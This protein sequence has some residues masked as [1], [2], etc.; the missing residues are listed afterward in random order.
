[1]AFTCKSRRVGLEAGYSASRCAVGRARWVWARS[2]RS[3]W[4]RRAKKALE[5]RKQL[6]DGLDPIG[7]RDAALAKHRLDAAKA[8]T[9]SECQA[10]YIDAHRSS[11]HNVKHAAQWESTLKT[12]AAPTLGALPVQTVDVDLVTRVLEPIWHSKPETAA[13]LRGR[14]EAI[15]DWATVR[16]Q[17]IGDN[18]ARWRGNLQK[19]LPARSKVKPVEHHPALAFPELPVFMA[20]L[21]GQEGV[22]ARALEFTILTAARTGEVIGAVPSEIDF[23]AK[24][25][26]IPTARMKAKR[27]HRVPLSLASLS[28]I[29]AMRQLGNDHFLFPGGRAVLRSCT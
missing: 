1:V 27:E 17:R 23:V 19:L 16:G 2:R 21:R 24:A 20:S 9:F 11:W 13:R 5:C 12:Y 18:P 15:L 6:A 8:L 22:A 28:I 4:P 10:K 3:P 26:T 29:K 7:A 14:I 25:W